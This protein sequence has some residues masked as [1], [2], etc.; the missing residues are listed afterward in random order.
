MDTDAKLVNG[1]KSS[2]IGATDPAKVQDHRV[3]GEEDSESNSLLPPRRGGI[4]RKSEKTR[5]KVQWNDKNG[6]KL[7]EVL[8]FYPSDASDSDDEDSD[9]CIC[10]VM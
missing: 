5:L 10:T 6:N 9:S 2:T 1:Y 8:E 3:N 4:S 7:A